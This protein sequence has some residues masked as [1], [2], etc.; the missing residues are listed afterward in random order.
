V[1][2]HEDAGRNREHG[3]DAERQDLAP[4]DDPHSFRH[5]GQDQDRIDDEEHAGR[6]LRAEAGRRHRHEYQTGAEA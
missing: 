5:E 1:Q 6:D 3:A 2:E 4:V